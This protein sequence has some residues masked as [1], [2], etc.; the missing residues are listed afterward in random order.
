[1][2]DFLELD[3]SILFMPFEEEDENLHYK[4]NRISNKPSKVFLKVLF[5]LIPFAIIFELCCLLS[6]IIRGY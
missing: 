2:E 6:Y 3:L 1:M 4:I 5:I